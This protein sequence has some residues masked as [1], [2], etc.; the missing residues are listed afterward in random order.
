MSYFAKD[1]YD[2]KAEF[3]ARRMAENAKVKSLTPEQHE[4]LAYLCSIRH[5]I[6]S[7]GVA[8]MWNDQ[9]VLFD[10]IHAEMRLN[11]LD[12]NCPYFYDEDG[13][14]EDGYLVTSDDYSDHDSD[15]WQEAHDDCIDD[16]DGEDD[17]DLDYY[18]LDY[19]QN[20]LG[21]QLEAMNRRIE[22]YL[23]RIDE[24]YGTDYEPSGASRIF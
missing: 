12:L 3:A 4:A 6:H 19:M 18:I 16:V 5:E 13:T 8:D 11:D 22:R 14:T 9:C 21:D 1:V 23:R 24:K 2:G 10:L 15:E 7:A 20:K 17:P